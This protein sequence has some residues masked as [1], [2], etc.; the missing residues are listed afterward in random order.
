[1]IA[2]DAKASGCVY[3]VIHCRFN[4]NLFFLCLD[5]DWSCIQLSTLSLSSLAALLWIIGSY[6]S[7]GHVLISI[8]RLIQYFVSILWPTFVGCP[9]SF[10]CFSLLA[11][12]FLSFL[13]HIGQG[14]L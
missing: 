2:F 12:G 14:W 13:L 7:F 8:V 9:L 3:E 1:M 6:D 11:I 4:G 5:F 10:C